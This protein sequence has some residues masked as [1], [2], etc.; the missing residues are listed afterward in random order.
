MTT[1]RHICKFGESIF[2]RESRTSDKLL[3]PLPAKHGPGLGTHG[4]RQ[5]RSSPSMA[6]RHDA[7]AGYAD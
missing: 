7:R 5:L 3:S 2:I 6:L 4:M 1:S